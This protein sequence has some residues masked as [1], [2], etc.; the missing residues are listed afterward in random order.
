VPRGA[1]G[2]AVLTPSTLPTRSILTGRG[3]ANR[4]DTF[5]LAGASAG[6]GTS[7]TAGRTAWPLSVAR[8]DSA[9]TAAPAATIAKLAAVTEPAVSKLRRIP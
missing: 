4:P 8:T 5:R 1:F 7:V 9:A 2:S 6:G 3:P